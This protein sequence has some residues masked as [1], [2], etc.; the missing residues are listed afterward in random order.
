MLKEI[1]E[2]FCEIIR[3]GFWLVF[4]EFCLFVLI[5]SF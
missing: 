3:I 1:K 5:L 2:E 4:I